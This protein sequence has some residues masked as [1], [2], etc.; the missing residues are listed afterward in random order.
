LHVTP[1][2]AAEYP[3]ISNLRSSIGFV[4]LPQSAF[5]EAT[6]MLT[7]VI[8][9][10]DVTVPLHFNIR[11]MKSESR[12]FD[13]NQPMENIIQMGVLHAKSFHE[14]A[15]TCQD[16]FFFFLFFLYQRFFRLSRAASVAILPSA[17]FGERIFFARC[18]LGVLHSVGAAT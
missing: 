14:K 15:G 10:Q 9:T 16:G 12:L 2:A 18:K 13:V 6:E 7:S 1:K 11:H 4:G 17:L 8:E 3:T 5:A